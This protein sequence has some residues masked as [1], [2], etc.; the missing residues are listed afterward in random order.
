MNFAKV[1]RTPF[2]QNITG[3]LLLII[4]VSIIIKGE[5][6]K[7]SVNNDRKLKQMYQNGSKFEPEV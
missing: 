1:V 7:E 5:L 2:L 6:A 4:A 3:R